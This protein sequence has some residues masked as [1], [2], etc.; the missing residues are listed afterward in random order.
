MQR[1]LS[2]Y[3]Y[4]NQTLSPALLTEVAHAGF[5]QLE[6][7]ASPSHFHY[8]DPKSLR[9]VAESLEENRLT[10]H[11]VHAPTERNRAVSRESGIPISI[12]D[13]ERVRRLDAVDEIK[14]ALEIAEQIPF[15]LLVQHMGHG[16]QLADGRRID[17]AFN[18]LEHLEI[19]AKQRGVT[20]ALENTPGE[21][22][23]PL[24]LHQFIADTHLHGLRLC[25]D[26]G[27]AHIEDGIQA[28]L[29]AM[30][31][32]VINLHVHDNHGEKDEHLVPLA[33]ES[34]LKAGEARS[35]DNSS[36][37]SAIAPGKRIDWDA[38]LKLLAS[39]PLGVA[40][41][42]LPFV[43]ELKEQAASS[44]PTLGQMRA[45]FD[46]LEERLEATKREQGR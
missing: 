30:H 19:F 35:R 25:L 2:T 45:A 12:S 28:S 1:V 38:T 43:L 9:D 40:F 17:A 23:S 21:L 5:T 22:G 44:T 33:D 27:H 14:W 31:E 10:L 15:N 3:R 7:F 37:G 6:I 26:L 16:R 4:V 32:R 20:I 39:T 11:S 13:P 34:E 36:R 29:D 24:T 41:E 46:R 42:S 8:R 18:S